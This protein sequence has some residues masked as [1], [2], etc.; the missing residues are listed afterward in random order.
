[1]E[2]LS[3]PFLKPLHRHSLDSLHQHKPF[4]IIHKE[5]MQR[6]FS[7]ECNLIVGP[8]LKSEM[9]CVQ[10]FVPSAFV[11]SP[12]LGSWMSLV[13]GPFATLAYAISCYF[14]YAIFPS[15]G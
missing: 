12:S 3:Y 8:G 1:M 11:C 5:V 7:Q 9:E 2:L 13:L 15:L 10:P 6:V 4:I 14:V